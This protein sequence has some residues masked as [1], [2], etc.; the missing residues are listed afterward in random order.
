MPPL[1]ALR[2]ALCDKRIS[3]RPDFLPHKNV[4]TDSKTEKGDG[5]KRNQMWRDDKEA[6]QKW[7]WILKTN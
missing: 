6:L 3:D 4:V 7:K 2:Y 1:Y 5:H